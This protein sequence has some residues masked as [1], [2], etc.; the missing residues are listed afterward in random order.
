MRERFAWLLLAVTGLDAYLADTTH[1]VVAAAF[2]AAAFLSLLGSWGWSRGPAER[3]IVLA[4]RAR[5]P[6]CHVGPVV[7][8]PYDW[9]GE[10]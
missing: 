10:L 6:E 9:E 4:R 8:R 7:G 5:A 1:G 3:S 2:I